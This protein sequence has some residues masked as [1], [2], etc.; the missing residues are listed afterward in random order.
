MLRRRLGFGTGEVGFV[1]VGRW[2]SFKGFARTVRAFWRVARVCPEERLLLLGGYDPLH[3][4]GLSAEER[5]RVAESRQVVVAGDQERVEEYLAAS[6][7]MVFPSEREGMSVCL[8]EALAMGVPVLTS[9]ARGC[10]DVVRDGVDG[11]VLGDGSEEALAL[12][13]EAVCRDGGLRARYAEAA[14][15]G[16]GRFCRGRFIEEQAGFYAMEGSCTA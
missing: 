1:F 2:T 10:A 8:M 11:E 6:D 16:R 4:S 14:L 12:R 9:T 7:V 15:E 5:L 13:M 3:G